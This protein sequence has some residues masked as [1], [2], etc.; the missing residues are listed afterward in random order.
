LAATR[1]KDVTETQAA[2]ETVHYQAY[3][4]LLTGLPNRALFRDHLA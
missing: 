3:H 1:R 4:D 2:E